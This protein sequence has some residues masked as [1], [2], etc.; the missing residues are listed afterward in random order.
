MPILNQ[1]MSRKLRRREFLATSAGIFALSGCLQERKSSEEVKENKSDSGIS[2]S[3][4]ASSSAT[5]KKLVPNNIW[6]Y[7]TDDTVWATPTVVNGRVYVGSNDG[8]MYSFGEVDE[9]SLDWEDNYPMYKWNLS[10]TNAPE[11]HGPKGEI[12]KK[13]EFKTGGVVVSSP[14]A[15][16]GSLY[17]GS[18]DGR[19]YSV[20]AKTGKEK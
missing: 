8:S 5:Y 1:D 7:M 15:V 14:A 18:E 10:N 19:F 2:S 13:W 16:D 12:E 11:S 20:D 4:P 6:E 3:V 9:D 17:F